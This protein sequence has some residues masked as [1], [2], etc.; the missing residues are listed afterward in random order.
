M[1][2]KHF[3]T[4]KINLDNHKFILLYGQNEGQKESLE[5]F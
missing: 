4:N 3:E 5:I 2:I 1:I